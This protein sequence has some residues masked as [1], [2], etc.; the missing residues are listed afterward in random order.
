MVTP[1]RGTF[2]SL[3]LLGTLWAASGGFSAAMEALNI[4]YDAEETRPFWKTRPLSIALTL[5]IGLL[6]LVALAIMIVGPHFGLWLASRIHLSRIWLWVWPYIHWTI[7]VG[8]AVLAVEAF[9]FL[10]PMS[11]SAFG[12]PYPVPSFPS[13]FGLC[14][15]T[16]W[17]SISEHMQILTRLTE[18][19]ALASLSW[20]GCTGPASQCWLERS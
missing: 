13:A 12:P 6:L 4:A 1:Y 8:F 16:F 19:S 3:G 5:L 11:S 17:A 9:Y 15:F 10:A 7:S 14:S 18:R 20:S 2:L